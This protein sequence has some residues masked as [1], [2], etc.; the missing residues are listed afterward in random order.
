MFNPFHLKKAELLIYNTQKCKHRVPYSQHPRCFEREVLHGN[1]TPRIGFFDLE[2]QNFKANYGILLT[3]SIKEY[4]KKKIYSGMIT[5]KDIRSKFLDKN[6]TSQI[7]KDFS[8]FDVIVTYYGTRCDIPYLRTRSMKWDIPFPAY[9]YIKHIDLYG[10][11]KTKLSLNRNSLENACSL[12]GIKGKNHVFGDIW[13]RAVTGHVKSLEYILE[14]N[15]RDVIIL[16]KLYDKLIIHSARTN[17]S[18]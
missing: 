5:Q 4:K 13:M 7:V 11:V 9:G 14:H 17:R 15:K 18:I 2:F 6:L 1:H 3:Y 12:V 16:E 8:K 10:L